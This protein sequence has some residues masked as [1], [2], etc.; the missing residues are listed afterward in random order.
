[1]TAD[2]NFQRRGGGPIKYYF[3][4]GKKQ[5]HTHKSLHG[6]QKNPY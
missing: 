2:K 6:V 1:M 5:H 3:L 4:T